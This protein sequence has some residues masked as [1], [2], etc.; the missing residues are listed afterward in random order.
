MNTALVASLSLACIAGTALAQPIALPQIPRLDIQHYTQPASYVG[1]CIV[2]VRTAT[3]AQLDALFDMGASAWSERVG[4]GVIEVQIDRKNLPLLSELGI[5]YDMLIP[6]LQAHQDA[7]WAMVRAQQADAQGPRGGMVHDDAWFSNYKQFADIIAYFNNIASVRPDL[8]TMSD[9]G[10]SLLGSNIYALTI[11]AP[12]LAGNARADRPVVLWNG[13][14][15]AR[16]WISPMTVSYLASKLVDD[17]GNDQRVTDILRS[18]R[19]VIV[20]VV[21]PDGYLYTWSTERYWR[22]NRR[23]NGNG[24]F[25]V[26]LNRNWGYE[27][28]GQGASSF[29]GDDTY[30]GASAFS[31]PETQTMRDL[32]MSYGND[33]VAHIDYHSYSQLILWPF[34][35]A[36]GVQTPEPDRT[37]FDNLSRAMSDEILAYSGAFYDPIQS[38]DL[39]PA[40]GDS[41][42]WFYGDLGAKSLTVELRPS[43]GGLGGFDPPPS[44]ILP[45][46][47]E[48]YEAAKLFVER[49]TQALSFGFEPLDLVEAG[50]P[51]PVTLSVSDVIATQDPSTAMLHARIGAS[52]EVLA[53]PMT[54]LGNDEYTA[55]LPASPCG[56]YVYYS[57]SIDTSDGVSV[58]YPSSGEFSALAQEFTISVNDE[59]ETN[60]GWVVGQPSD[61]ATTG[62]WNRMDPHGTA[63]QPEDDHTPGAGVDC[64]VTDGNAG[65]SL[66]A[67][68][69]DGGATTLTSPALDASAL[70]DDAELSYWRWYSNNTG[71]SPDEDSMLVQI[72]DDDGASWSTLEIVSE[73]A[74][75]WVQK[76]FRIADFV[77]ATSAVRVRFVASDLFNGSIVE[78]GVDDLLV[79]SV[80]CSANPADLNGDGVLDFFDVSLFLS[81][82]NA[83]DPVA[84]FNGDGSFDF[85]DVS[86]FLAAFNA[87]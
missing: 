80:G 37:Y 69:I 12:D 57:F 54:A 84:D 47:R 16:E 13:T 32:A 15:H 77:S 68:D 2:R 73:N 49:T 4:V 7:Q 52:D 31:E 8:A 23:N 50:T 85:F 36:D 39:Y 20:P 40:A 19:I 78:A 30:H 24:T 55:D 71:A 63:A 86:A 42:D 70:G 74:G 66:G 35:Y 29:S 22:K 67:N 25:G 1:Q 18:A 27:W 3:R 34:G 44:T 61:T 82:Y 60:T 58:N 21:N 76:S 56:Q 33:L 45:T 26:D 48:N 9:V 75:R 51:T 65:G 83:Q 5:G 62:V 11:S 87:G 17:Y 14:Q 43:A 38:V 79:Q 41:S 59:M 72:S 81:A 6:D 53:I 28:G 64:W 10:D 46:A